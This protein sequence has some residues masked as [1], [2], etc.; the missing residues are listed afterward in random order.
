MGIWTCADRPASTHCKG[1]GSHATVEGASMTRFGIW[2]L[3]HARAGVETADLYA[4]HIAEMELA[5][6]LGFDEYWVSEHIFHRE[7]SLLPSPSL[8][9]A[10][11]ADR[12]PRLRL[13][14]LVH[15]LPF[16]DPL[17]LAGECTMLDHLTR[18]R[19]SVG[20]GR[21]ARLDEYR[22]VGIDQG[23]SRARFE[24][25]AELILRLWTEDRVDH[26]G[27]YF[28]CHDATLAPRPYQQPHPPLVMATIGDDSLYWAAE[29]AIGATR[30]P[31][32]A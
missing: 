16:H 32:T 22:R 2:D 17:R 21:G 19:L 12:V 14:V 31:E 25:A 20:I 1:H 28:H 5:E 4:E 29:R 6:A 7:H 3:V 30:G 11:A 26:Q 13:G 27:R 9:L 15:V 18:G 24:E 23:E 8:L 10:A